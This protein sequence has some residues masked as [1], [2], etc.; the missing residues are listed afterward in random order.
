[1]VY[2]NVLLSELILSEID[3]IKRLKQRHNAPV[4]DHIDIRD[5][6]YCHAQHIVLSHRESADLPLVMVGRTGVDHLRKNNTFCF[7]NTTEAT[8]MFIKQYLC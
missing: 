7:T 3:C 4:L 5:E 2:G 6:R 1:M 8:N